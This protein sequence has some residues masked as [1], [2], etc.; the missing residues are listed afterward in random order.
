MATVLRTLQTP[1]ELRVLEHWCRESLSVPGEFAECG[2]HSGGVANRLCEILVEEGVEK[3]VHLFDSW[4]I[5]ASQ[6]YDDRN[7]MRQEPKTAAFGERVRAA[8]Q[9]HKEAIFHVGLFRETLPPFNVPLSFAHVDSDLYF[10]T[11][12]ACCMLNRC[13]VDGGVAV[14]HDYGHPVWP[15]VKLAVDHALARDWKLIRQHHNQAIF[16]RGQDL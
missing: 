2:V 7:P 13:M 9:H 15:G 6:S 1:H 10:S 11:L 12:D 16:M 8:L 14:F 3:Q 4:N 5:P